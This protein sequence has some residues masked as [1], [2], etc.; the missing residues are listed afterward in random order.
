MHHSAI[1]SRAS[2]GFIL[3]S[4]SFTVAFFAASA[5]ACGSL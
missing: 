5:I 1:N 4:H 3:P 2:A